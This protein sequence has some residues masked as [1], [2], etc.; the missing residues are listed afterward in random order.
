M[1]KKTT[2]NTHTSSS[3]KNKKNAGT[4][5]AKPGFWKKLRSG[6]LFDPIKKVWR[7]ENVR[8]VIGL[9]ILL[10]SI[11]L[12]FS[13]ASNI[14]TGRAD[15]GGVQS[16][17]LTHA[18]NFCGT[19]GAIVSNY[20]MDIC[21]GLAAFFIPFIFILLGLKLMG[22]YRIR[23]W[24]WFLNFSILMI[25]FSLFFSLI[26]AWLPD[27][28]INQLSFR[29]GGSHG[30][31]IN[32]YLTTTLGPIGVWITIIG[33]AILYLLYLTNE[34]ITIVRRLMHPQD[35]IKLKKKH[36]EEEVPSDD[37]AAEKE[38]ETEDADDASENESDYAHEETDA[39][40]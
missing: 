25:W 14:V 2:S 4:I 30:D 39:A 15:Q 13:F 19:L 16:G 22:A 32:A 5:P 33:T 27:S 1:A 23:L 29:L 6:E 8:F 24:K 36:K 21:F 9:L 37:D 35:F 31:Y 26:T 12:L 10:S 18:A 7:A 38:E 34:T 40:E 28:V 3:V 20:F 11:L 17:T